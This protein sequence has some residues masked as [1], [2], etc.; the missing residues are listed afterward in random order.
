MP[1]I[2]TRKQKIRKPNHPPLVS[3][4]FSNRATSRHGAAVPPSIFIGS[5]SNAKNVSGRFDKCLRTRSS[6]A[7]FSKT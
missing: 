3:S 7:T 2:A 5:T 4:K 6:A 1:I